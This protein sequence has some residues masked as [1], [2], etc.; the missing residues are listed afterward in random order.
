MSRFTISGDAAK[1][2][3]EPGRV[4]DPGERGIPVQ[5]C[6][7]PV[8]VAG[9]GGGTDVELSA[10]LEQPAG[11]L[12]VTVEGGGMD[13]GSREPSAPRSGVGAGVEQ[14]L[15]DFGAA[16]RGGIVQ[17]SHVVA[18]PPAKAAPPLREPG[19]L[20]QG[21]AYGGG[22]AAFAGFHE[23]AKPFDRRIG[24]QRAVDDV[25]V[26]LWV[27]PQ[28]PPE[29]LEILDLERV[30]AV[31]GHDGVGDFRRVD[32]VTDDLARVPARERY[33]VELA[34]P[35]LKPSASLRGH[36]AAEPEAYHVEPPV[37]GIQESHVLGE[38]LACRVV[39]RRPRRHVDAH[40]RALRPSELGLDR[41]G[42]D[43]VGDA[44]AGGRFQ[45]VADADDVGRHD[46]LRVIAV[47]V[48]PGGQM[49]DRVAALGGPDE[50]VE[51]A[52]VADRGVGEVRGGPPVEPG[53][54]ITAQC[55]LDVHLADSAGGAGDENA[56][57]AHGIT[58]PRRGG[59]PRDCG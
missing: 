15:D 55:P 39:V 37:A 44:G 4:R 56:I 10:A 29:R 8:D 48:R 21:L 46:L 26:L 25:R 31:R 50:G 57:P 40:L 11:D 23:L 34:R 5:D 6:L 58:A 13:R 35:P 33:G 12:R 52:E 22:V 19:I 45:D 17:R 20:G 14:D 24:R 7:Q 30:E 3:G 2:R 59:A 51:V 41:G 54:V 47:G 43:D 42:E 36:D 1:C 9:A 38:N 32:R 16:V 18:F 53:E 49:Q 28:C 27:V